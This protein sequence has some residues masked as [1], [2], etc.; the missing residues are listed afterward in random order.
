MDENYFNLVVALA[1]YEYLDIEKNILHLLT[2][3]IT[4]GF[5]WNEI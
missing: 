1:T 3:V 5:K 4:V 2:D